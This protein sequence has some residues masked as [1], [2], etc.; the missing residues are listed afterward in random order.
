MIGK[1]EA[2]AEGDPARQYSAQILAKRKGSKD[3]YRSR[4]SLKDRQENS[5]AFLRENQDLYRVLNARTHSCMRRRRKKSK[6]K[7]VI[8]A[9]YNYVKNIY[10]WESQRDEGNKSTNSFYN[11]RPSTSSRTKASNLHQNKSSYLHFIGL[12]SAM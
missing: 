5:V 8:S 4:S 1:T 2:E 9:S 11:G 12:G 3:S 10:G 7:K 6:D